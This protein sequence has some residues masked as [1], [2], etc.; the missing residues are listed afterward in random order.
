MQEKQNLKT[1]EKGITLIA[2]VITIIILLIL[3]A[4]TIAALSGDNGILRNA[5]NAKQETERAQVVE[6]AQVDILGKQA[7]NTSAELGRD[8]IKE[9]LDNY[10]ITVPDDFTSDTDLKTKP[11]YGDYTIKVSEIYSGEIEEAKEII[12]NEESFVGYYADMDPTD[13]KIDG[14]IYADLAKGGKGVWNDDSWSGYEYSAVADGL[15]EYYVSGEYTDQYFKTKQVLSP[16]EGSGT[17]D[18]FYVMALEDFTTSDYTTFYWY[19]NA[20][21]K[22]N[23][24][25]NTDYD[26]FGEGKANT[27]AMVNDWNNNT[28]TYGA[29][30]E[31]DL[32]GVIQNGSYEIVTSESDSGK[33]FVPSKAEWS[34]F[35]DAFKITSSNYDDVYGLNYY[36]WSS[37]QYNA[38]NAYTAHFDS[39]YI[40]YFTVGTNYH[41]RLSAT[42]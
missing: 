19:D 42:F 32:W 23:R 18:R 12:S 31:R 6:Q 1:K 15:K 5:A 3:A 4:V 26:D 30:N 36:Y 10:F 8:E 13:G 34:A 38:R 40:S 9:V 39:G 11:E 21:G 35:G 24:P 14:I 22:L 7:D 33:W 29:Q 17:V 37:S 25:I 20:Y 16:I 2:L 28:A 41:V 27:I